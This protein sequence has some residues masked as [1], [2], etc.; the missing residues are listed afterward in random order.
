MAASTTVGY[1]RV[2]TTKQATKGVSLAAQEEA[3]EAYVAKS[4]DVLSSVYQDVVSGKS[5]D[6]QGIKQLIVAIKS[7]RITK[8]VI[9]RL[10]RLSRDVTDVLSFLD[11]LSEHDVELVSI[12]EPINN[13]SL[14]QQRFSVSIIA[15]T[16]QLE[17]AIIADN[18]YI[19]YKTKHAKGLPLSPNVP[20]GYQLKDKEMIV[21][22]GES[23]RVKR[24]YQLYLQ[25]WGY[26]KI[27][28]QLSEEDIS[29]SYPPY[30]IR[31]ILLN[32]RYTGYIVNRYGRVKGKHEAMIT[33]E[34]FNNVQMIRQ[35]KRKKQVSNQ[36]TKQRAFLLRQRLRCPYCQTTLTCRTQY[37]R[38]QSYYSYECPTRRNRGHSYCSG[39]SCPAYFIEQE[40]VKVLQKFVL[41]DEVQ[42]AINQKAVSKKQAKRNHKCQKE[43]LIHQF[44]KGA[45]SA[46]DLEEGL[47]KLQ[48]VPIQ[49]VRHPLANFVD[50]VNQPLIAERK[51]SPLM[52]HR[53]QTLL[54]S[55][56]ITKDKILAT[57]CLSGGIKINRKE[58]GHY[59]N[60]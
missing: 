53:I 1:V 11:I 43:T 41:S 59:E 40:V 47:K 12:T 46:A 50:W 25:G 15:A 24:I 19:S 23:D 51:P 39:F 31:S 45:I 44:S 10:N 56:E 49:E 5:M 17:R 22:K 54:Q 48:E 16:G 9:Y 29:R 6:R 13:G 18:Q 27:G 42:A 3:I 34:V 26:Q 2:S 57:L 38:N 58:D 30:F 14:A 52:Y 37:K 36:R 8:V 28:K 55:V 35:N 32:E 21:V 4:G 7:G 60:I 33:P 20:F